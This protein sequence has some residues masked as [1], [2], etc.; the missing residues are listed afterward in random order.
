MGFCAAH[1]HRLESASE[2][3]RAHR[4]RHLLRSRRI[5]QLS[6]AQRRRRLQRTVW[7]NACAAL[8][9]AHCRAKRRDVCSSVWH[10]RARPSQP[11]A[12]RRFRLCFPTSRRPIS[13]NYPAGKPFG[14]FLFGGYDINNKL[15]YTENWTFD[16]QY[17]ASNSW[18]FSA[19]Y[20]GNHGVHEILPIPFNQPGIA[21]P[22]NPINGQ[23]YSYGGVSPNYSLD[24]EPISTCEYSGNAPI[25]VP[26]IGYDMNSVLFKAEGISNYNALQLA[27]S[28]ASFERLQFTASYTWSHALDEQSGLGLFFTGNNP[29]DAEV[30]ATRRPTSTRPTCS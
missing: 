29:T 17:Q 6:L 5:L 22:Q 27:G 15:P 13:G 3:D 10:D 7:R 19:G 26:Y 2:A 28:Q 12:P 14:P 8:R 25:R 23:I 4:I 18:L 9:S 1:R 16:L 21:T 24:L 11:A 20:V 30:R